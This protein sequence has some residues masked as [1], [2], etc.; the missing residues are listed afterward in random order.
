MAKRRFA[1]NY[2]REDTLIVLARVDQHTDRPSG[3]DMREDINDTVNDYYIAQT[4]RCI[5]DV[6]RDL[7]KWAVIRGIFIF[8]PGPVWSLQNS[9]I[10]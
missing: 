10:L 3:P 8:K 9:F 5:I 4:P 1:L 2:E 6:S 7:I